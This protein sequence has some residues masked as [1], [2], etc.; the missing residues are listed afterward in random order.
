MANNVRETDPHPD[1]S[2]QAGRGDSLAALANDVRNP[3]QSPFDKATGFPVAV[4]F[5]TTRRPHVSVRA[6]F[7][8]P[9]EIHDRV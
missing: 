9:E 5:W 6:A 3:V 1:F 2:P 4:F 7:C 8:I